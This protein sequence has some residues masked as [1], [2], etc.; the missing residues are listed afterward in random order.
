MYVEEKQ[1]EPGQTADSQE[2]LQQA[3][4]ALE[5]FGV[6]GELRSQ[7]AESVRTYD[8]S[9]NAS[10]AVEE[11]LALSDNAHIIL[12]QRY[13][14]KDADNNPIETPEGLF[15]RV[16]RAIANGESLRTGSSGRANSTT[17]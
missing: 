16:A 6:P 4:Q 10:T 12:E 1:V 11:A 9:H 7:V 17:C 13:L 5:S 2:R 14:R 3:L 8:A 15:R